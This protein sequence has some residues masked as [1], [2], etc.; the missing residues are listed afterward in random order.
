MS[1]LILVILGLAVGAFGTLIGA[2]GGFILVPVLLIAYPEKKPE[3]ITSI[4]LAVVCLNAASGSVAYAFKKRIDYKSALIFCITTL[5]GSIIG[6]YLTGYIP[7]HVF[8]LVFGLMLVMIS[9]MLIIKPFR[10]SVAGNDLASKF[11]FPTI[12]K[13]T[14]KYG[15]KY[16]YRYDII[17]ACILSFFVG[18]ASSLLGIGG[19][20]I[21]VPAMVNLLNFPVHIATATSHFVLALMGFSGSAVHWLKGDLQEGLHQV[22]WLGVGVIGGAQVGAALSNKVKEAIIIRSL[23]VALGIV[24]IRILWMV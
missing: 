11:I 20:I 12:R 16:T 19:G 9:A 7:R 13:M 2:G 10:S 3:L 4:S 6:S 15:E 18:I 24:A 8:N 22:I 14:D 1:V 17:T 23:A 21:H 5:P